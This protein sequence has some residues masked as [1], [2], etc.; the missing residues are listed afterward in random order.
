M[1]KS[2]S[3]LWSD[4]AGYRGEYSFLGS[5]GSLGIRN[6]SR[7]A[8]VLTGL[9]ILF[10]ALLLNDSLFLVPLSGELSVDG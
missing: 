5:L 4:D 7:T 1:S 8:R 10:S 3:E 6:G 2:R 9:L